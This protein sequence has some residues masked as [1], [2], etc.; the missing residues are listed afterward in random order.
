MEAK[1]KVLGGNKVW[2]PGLVAELREANDSE[3]LASF[4]PLAIEDE[5]I[6]GLAKE[7]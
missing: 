2:L 5:G 3:G 7:N 6:L 1:P 4:A